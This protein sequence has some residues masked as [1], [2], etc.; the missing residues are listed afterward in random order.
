MQ[1]SQYPSFEREAIH[2]IMGK[3]SVTLTKLLGSTLSAE[4]TDLSVLVS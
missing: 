4:Q 3:V 2:P 1:S